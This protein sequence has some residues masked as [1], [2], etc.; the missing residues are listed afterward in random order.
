MARSA[1]RSS[2]AAAFATSLSFGLVTHAKVS[3]LT[4]AC[5]RSDFSSFAGRRWIAASASV[6]VSI[7]AGS[8]SQFLVLTGI[9]NVAPTV[10][11]KAFGV[12]AAQN[13]VL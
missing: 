2:D 5:Q 12:T 11:A 1:A 10:D 4:A 9:A 8:T 3:P 13:G 7:F 6:G